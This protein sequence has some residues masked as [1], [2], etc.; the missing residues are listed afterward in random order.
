MSNAREL[1]DLGGVVTVENGN[2]GIGAP[3]PGVKLDVNGAVRVGT[4][5]NPTTIASNAQLYDQ[6]NI[7]PTISGFN[8][9]VRTAAVGDA[10]VERLRVR[11]DGSRWTDNNTLPAFECR[12]W[13]NFDGQTG[14]GNTVRASGNVSSVTRNSTGIYTVNYT[15]AMPDTNYSCSG[16]SGPDG[17]MH[18]LRF[19]GAEYLT[20]STQIQTIRFDNLNVDR[21]TVIFQVFR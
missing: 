11:S 2:V 13:V 18:A 4:A 6:A 1:G 17:T 15:T 8:F 9:T 3:S 16:L 5:A 12:A 7:G 10:P 19:T 20:T 21:S 14:S